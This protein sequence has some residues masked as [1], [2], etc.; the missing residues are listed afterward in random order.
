MLLFYELLS[1]GSLCLCVLVVNNSHLNRSIIRFSPPGHKEI[2]RFLSFFVLLWLT[3][4]ACSMTFQFFTTKTRRHQGG[5]PD[6]AHS[7]KKKQHDEGNRQRTGMMA[8]C[9]T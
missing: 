2:I 6:G 3:I 1:S 4:L 8:F 5:A 7:F 9:E